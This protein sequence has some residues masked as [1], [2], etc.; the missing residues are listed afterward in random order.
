MGGDG[1]RDGATDREAIAAVV[2]RYCHLLDDG[3]WDEFARLW[4]DDAEFVL[5]GQTTTGRQAIRAAIEASQPPER[6]GRHLATNLELEVDGDRATN[7]CDFVFW[8]RGKD[9]VVAPLFLG[10][11]D[12]TLVR[13][14]EGW[15]FSRREITFF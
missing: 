13:S 1:M 14:A 8:A 3:R 4:S 9:G 5:Q 7:V 15:Q 12:D 2:A 6:R 10:R 11:Y